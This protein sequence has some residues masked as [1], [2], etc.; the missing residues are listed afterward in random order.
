METPVPTLQS[1]KG[2]NPLE[3][4]LR[5]LW[6][7]RLGGVGLI[8]PVGEVIS[9]VREEARRDVRGEVMREVGR[10]GGFHETIMFC[11]K[12]LVDAAR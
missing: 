6:A 8:W 3:G 2:K 10:H 11:K 1:K 7:E 12:G 9:E 5:W 4:L